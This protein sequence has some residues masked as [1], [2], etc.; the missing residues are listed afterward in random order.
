MDRSHWKFKTKNQIALKNSFIVKKF[1]QESY[2]L[3]MELSKQKSS[4]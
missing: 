4:G 1:T 2:L 3:F